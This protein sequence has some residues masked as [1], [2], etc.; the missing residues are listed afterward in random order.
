MGVDIDLCVYICDVMNSKLKKF[1]KM[2]LFQ[3]FPVNT[4]HPNKR[5]GLDGRVTEQKPQNN[6]SSNNLF[7]SDLNG[8][9]LLY[10]Q[11]GLLLCHFL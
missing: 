10:M 2:S 6:E 9:T 3:T 7:A 4:S 1:N 11:P 5:N 8:P